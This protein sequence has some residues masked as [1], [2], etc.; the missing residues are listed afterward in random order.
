[1]SQDER[2]NTAERLRY[3][4]Y[5]TL[6]FFILITLI[7]WVYLDKFS[8]YPNLKLSGS[9]CGRNGTGICEE[10]TDSKNL[11]THAYLLFFMSLIGTGL[12]VYALYMLTAKKAT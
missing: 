8:E 5:P 11:K 10:Y 7:G 9:F 6:G 1:M 3:V 4:L 12:N 2:A